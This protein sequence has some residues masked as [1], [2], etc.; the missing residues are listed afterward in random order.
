MTKLFKLAVLLTIIASCS[1]DEALVERKQILA[2]QLD[3]EWAIKRLHLVDQDSSYTIVG[4]FTF[5]SCDMSEHNK[6]Q[7]VIDV[8][9]ESIPFTYTPVQWEGDIADEITITPEQDDN[10]LNFPTGGYKILTLNDSV[11]VLDAPYCKPIT[12]ESGCRVISRQIEF[13]KKPA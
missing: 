3:G 12:N 4:S 13:T 11:F 5:E 1:D 8:Y 6:C 10:Q 7:G 2:D 9:G